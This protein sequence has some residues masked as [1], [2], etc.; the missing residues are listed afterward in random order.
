MFYFHP[1]TAMHSY[2]EMVVFRNIST[3]LVCQS[4]ESMCQLTS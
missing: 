4:L 3:F 1:I 2:S